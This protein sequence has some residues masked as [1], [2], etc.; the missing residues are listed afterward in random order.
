MPLDVHRTKPWLGCYNVFE[1][2]QSRSETICLSKSGNDHSYKNLHPVGTTSD[3]NNR[4]GVEVTVLMEPSLIMN[5]I[6]S[7]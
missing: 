2:N 1:P 5:F 6:L 4:P 7:C 3:I